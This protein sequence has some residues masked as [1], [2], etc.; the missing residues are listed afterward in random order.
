MGGTRAS[1]GLLESKKHFAHNPVAMGQMLAKSFAGSLCYLSVHQVACLCVWEG[2]RLGQTRAKHAS[3]FDRS[4][5]CI[6]H[7]HGP[8]EPNPI[9]QSLDGLPFR[10]FGR[11]GAN[12]PGMRCRLPHRSAATFDH[13]TKRPAFARLVENPSDSCWLR[14]LEAST[15]SEIP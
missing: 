11:R 8:A 4:K 13:R 2:P 9:A 7:C 3:C 15:E 12:D 1:S 5:T 10:P 6:N 14:Y